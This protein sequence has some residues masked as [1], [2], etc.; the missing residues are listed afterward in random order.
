MPPVPDILQIAVPVPLRRHF[1][2]LAPAEYPRENLLPGIRIQ[3]P[4]GKRELTGI[5]LNTASRSDQ[6]TGKLRQAIRVI[7]EVPVLGPMLLGLGLRMADYYQTPVGEALLGML[8]ALLRQGKPR[9]D[10]LPQTSSSSLHVESSLVPNADQQATLDAIA[11]AGDAFNVFLLEGVT[12]SGKTEV[13]LQA[14]E[15]VLLAGKQVLV[16]VPEIGLTPQTLA[17]FRERFSLPVVALHS[18]MSEKKRLQHWQIAEA[19]IAR[20][21]IGTRSAIFTPLLNPGLIV[22]DE[23]HDTSFRQQDHFRYHARDVAILRAQMEGI[24]VILGSATPSLESLHNARAGRYRH[25]CLSGRAGGASLPV[26][27][28][29]DMR[30]QPVQSGLSEA[31]LA[32]VR[33]HLSAGNQVMLFLNRRG[34]APT[35]LCQECG[36][37]AICSRCDIRMTLHL[38]EGI[39]LCHHCDRRAKIPS[40]CPECRTEGLQATGQGTERLEENLS[41][42]FPQT[43]IVRI[44]RDATR[45]KGTLEKA[46]ARIHAGEAKLLAGTQML[47][48]GHHFPDVTLVGI[49]DADSGL[50]SADFRGPERMGQLLLQVAG[51]AGRAEKPGVVMIQTHHPDHPLLTLLLQEGYSAFATALLLERKQSLLPPFSYLALIRAEA[52]NA[53]AA[54]CFLQEMGELIPSDSTLSILGPVPAP[55]PKRAGRFR[56]QLLLQANLRSVLHQALK[57]ALPRGETLPSGKKVR[58][59]VDVDPVEMV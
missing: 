26:F 58:W 18:R 17:R 38:R 1:D 56:F 33:T 50:F 2:W 24:P 19:G 4:F 37:S 39:L 51:R 48:K 52:A 40:R 45:R 16:L 32:E 46:F 28:L 30:S 9:G 31:L 13:Y 53:Q 3:V 59:S 6:E 15:K 5:L 47:A 34:F 55:M 57:K 42:F 36:W 35:L 22:I 12:G 44:D 41:E 8:P 14:M 49:V 21:V 54:K 10:L 7:D 11:G 25:L 43:P 23:E 20:I 27:Q 29:T